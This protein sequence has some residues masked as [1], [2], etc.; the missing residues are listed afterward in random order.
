MW[1]QLPCCTHSNIVSC[2]SCTNFQ[3]CVDV[4]NFRPGVTACLESCLGWSPALW[5]L[6]RLAPPMAVSSLLEGKCSD[7][8]FFSFSCVL[9]LLMEHRT[10]VI[11]Y[12]KRPGVTTFASGPDRI[13]LTG[14]DFGKIE[15]QMVYT[16]L[17]LKQW[18]RHLTSLN[19]VETS[20]GLADA[21]NPWQLKI[22]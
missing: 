10:W 4:Y 20:G 21:K 22:Y 8:Y 13:Y 6:L 1:L 3:S 12:E 16:A 2:D 11:S 15:K 18:I 14:L 9:C 17:I 19:K 5:W 7:P